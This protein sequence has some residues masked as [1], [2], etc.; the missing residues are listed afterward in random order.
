MVA[1]GLPE[2]G[3]AYFSPAVNG[4]EVV[5]LEKVQNFS[6]RVFRNILLMTLRLRRCL[7]GWWQQN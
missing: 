3:M 7:S 4:E 2:A 6:T 1:H 5:G